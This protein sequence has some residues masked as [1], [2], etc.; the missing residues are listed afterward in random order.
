MA[1]S[2]RNVWQQKEPDSRPIRILVI[3]SLYPYRGDPTFGLFVARQ[4]AALRELGAT[5]DVVAMRRRGSGLRGRVAY[6]MWALRGLA[7]LVR[8]YDVVHAHYALPSGW[9]ALWHRR[10]KG[11]PSVITVHGSDVVAL[12][13]LH[14]WAVPQLTRVLQAADH[15]IAV[16]EFLRDQVVQRYQVSPER[17]SVQSMGIDCRVFRPD[18]PGAHEIRQRFG[19]QPLITYA[20]YLVPVKGLEHL[21]EAFARL[22]E[23]LGAGHL[24]LI[25]DAPDPAY[26]E[27]LV[28]RVEAAGLERH[29]TWTG[30]LPPER[31]ADYMAASDV[32]VLPS[33]REGLGL[34]ALEAMACGVPVVGSRV[35]GIPEIVE[36]GETGIL[37]EPGNASALAGAMRRALMDPDVRARCRQRGPAKA[38]EHDVRRR[39]VELL[40]LYR[41]LM[42]GK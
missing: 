7:R 37:V 2:G 38:A 32:F 20:G 35:G 30:A 12:P 10:L 14:P 15:V 18:R 26:K 42:T 1:V 13:D 40:A 31:L 36:D 21:I 27:V 9:V 39:A 22:R 19:E 16:S 41:L 24:V 28:A 34:V 6:G 8:R 23:R 5:V 11:I 4:V 33:I 29:V 17:V 25:G 3:T